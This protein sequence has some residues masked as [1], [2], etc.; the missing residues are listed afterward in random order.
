MK[1]PISREGL[2]KPLAKFIHNVMLLLTRMLQFGYGLVY[3][4]L[5]S[6]VHTAELVFARMLSHMRDIVLFIANLLV[7]VPYY[8]LF[9][10][11]FLAHFGFWI[12]EL[13]TNLPMN[14][15]YWLPNYNSIYADILD[16]NQYIKISGIA[17][18]MYVS[19]ILLS[20]EFKLF[21]LLRDLAFLILVYGNIVHYLEL[22]IEHSVTK[23]KQ[24]L[25]NDSPKPKLNL[26]ISG[27]HC[28]LA[29]ACYAENKRYPDLVNQIIC[30]SWNIDPKKINIVFENKN[31][32][33]DYANGSKVLY[34]LVGGRLSKDKIEH[35]DELK[36]QNVEEIL[37]LN[38]YDDEESTSLY[39]GSTV[40]NTKNHLWDFEKPS[41]SGKDRANL[42]LFLT[43]KTVF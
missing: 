35:L 33:D 10:A 6:P 29:S 8:C 16:N 23:T 20:G 22:V 36:R 15:G 25:E 17:I 9:A 32:Q 3:R 38:F 11:S 21:Y 19:T 43:S 14:L 2:R 28:L 42:E 12:L 5:Q 30:S 18:V 26:K 13:M 31:P 24:E 37:I 40:V 39:E 1:D 41:L 7:F 34:V 4:Q 27:L